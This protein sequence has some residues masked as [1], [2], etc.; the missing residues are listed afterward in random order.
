MTFH[1]VGQDV[2]LYIIERKASLENQRQ[3]KEIRTPS[4]DSGLSLRSAVSQESPGTLHMMSTNSRM[5]D[6]N[7]TEK[8]A[9]QE[10]LQHVSD[11][12]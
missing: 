5:A 1:K 9:G 2:L 6:S 3:K 11:S 7:H 10:K 4:I 12:D 8:G